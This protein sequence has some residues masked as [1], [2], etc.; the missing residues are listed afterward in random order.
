MDSW[1]AFTIPKPFARMSF[2]YGAPIRVSRAGGEA[3]LTRATEAVRSALFACET[4]A[5]QR[6]GAPCDW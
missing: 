2:V 1:D 4:E 5:F 6:V 3:E